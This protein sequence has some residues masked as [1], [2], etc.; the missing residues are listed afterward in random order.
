MS[1]LLYKR[2]VSVFL[3]LIALPVVFVAFVQAEYGES[4]IDKDKYSPVQ[5]LESEVEMEYDEDVLTVSWD[6]PDL[7]WEDFQ[8]YKLV[9]DASDASVAYPKGKSM[10]VGEDVSVS[11][12][13]VTSPKEG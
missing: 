7:E 4:Y 13:S 8:W 5:E 2:V 9:Y 6:A 12:Y 3:T 1:Q 11:T 10:Y